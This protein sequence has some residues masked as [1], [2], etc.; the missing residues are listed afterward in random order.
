MKYFAVAAGIAAL[1]VMLLLVRSLA[2]RTPAEPVEVSGEGDLTSQKAATAGE[3]GRLDDEIQRLVERLFARDG[4]SEFERLEAIGEQAVPALIGALEDPRT[5]AVKFDIQGFV[6]GGESAFERI[7]ELL[8]PFGPAEAVRPLEKYMQHQDDYFRKYAAVALGNIGTAECIAPMLVALDDA[9]ESVRSF[10][11]MGIQRGIEAE[12]CSVEFLD[13]MFPALTKLLNRDD[14]DSFGRAPQL[15]L[16]INTDRALPVLLSQEYFTTENRKLRYIIKALNV[17]GHRIPHEQLLP[18]LRSEQLL[19]DEYPRYYNYAEALIAYAHNPDAAAEDT[20]RAELRSTNTWVQEAAAEGLAI[21]SGISNARE[22]V[23]EAVKSEGFEKLSVP[24]KHYF[25]VLMYDAEVNNGGHSQ[26]FVNPTG[27][28]WKEAIAGLK[29]I[30]AENRAAI[31]LDATAVFGPAGPAVDTEARR[32]QLRA[33]TKQQEDFTSA[34]DGRYYNCEG[35][36][37]SLLS[38]YAI[39]NREHFGGTR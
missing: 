16:K 24:R 15:L 23:F 34:L 35:N 8:E 12:R 9:E 27:E 4:S 19:I 26:Y 3:L 32:K 2:H 36:I 7:N 20:L 13:A 10:A 38:Q 22:V 5:A 30:G 37:E 39:S 1:I 28:N 17:A 25:A 14:D 33:F 18:L 29:A 6:R 21:L 31:L 11:M